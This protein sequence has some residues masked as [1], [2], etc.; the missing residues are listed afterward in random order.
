ME[1]TGKVHFFEGHGVED[2][3]GLP[4]GFGIRVLE[5]EPMPS[6]R[7]VRICCIGVAVIFFQ[8]LLRFRVHSVCFSIVAAAAAAAA[9]AAEMESSRLQRQFFCNSFNTFQ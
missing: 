6:D 4:D 8:V 7:L 5:V 1:L 9:A 3:E 2:A